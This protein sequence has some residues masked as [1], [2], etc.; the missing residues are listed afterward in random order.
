MA[1][2][3]TKIKLFVC[4]GKKG[5]RNSSGQGWKG[6][7]V[8]NFE[9]STSSRRLNSDA[10]LSSPLLGGGDPDS[11]SNKYKRRAPTDLIFRYYTKSIFR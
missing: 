3:L 6:D 2:I 10:S 4:V 7:A 9:A 5:G 8:V 1:L 11:D